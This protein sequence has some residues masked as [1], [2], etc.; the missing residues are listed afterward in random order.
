MVISWPA[1]EFSNRP[2]KHPKWISD[3]CTTLI[4]R[5]LVWYLFSSNALD[6]IKS[7]EKIP[8]RQS[9]C[10]NSCIFVQN[11]C[12][13]IERK[14]I[15]W[16]HKKMRVQ[17]LQLTLQYSCFEN[18]RDV[19]NH[20]NKNSDSWPYNYCPT[21]ISYKLTIISH[22]QTAYP[23]W[24]RLD[25]WLLVVVPLS[26]KRCLFIWQFCAAHYGL[27]IDRAKVVFSVPLKRPER[28]AAVG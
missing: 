13:V 18:V 4:D 3:V 24:R 25:L 28:T 23:L 27:E 11:T 21:L 19:K 16:F 2:R 14:H 17:L 1:Y 9:M 5:S 22:C 10:L 20:M 12:S 7:G 26:S 8:F 15:V 6:Y